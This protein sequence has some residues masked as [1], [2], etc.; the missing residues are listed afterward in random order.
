M[1]N[2]V[3]RSACLVAL[4]GFS[5]V[6][7]SEAHSHTMNAT[8]TKQ[9]EINAPILAAQKPKPT[10]D[11]VVTS[12]ETV[13]ADW[14]GA[15]APTKR[16]GLKPQMAS[17]QIMDDLHLTSSLR[18]KMRPEAL[19]VATNSV[20]LTPRALSADRST[21]SSVQV[22]PLTNQQYGTVSRNSNLSSSFAAPAEKPL[23][24]WLADRPLYELGTQVGV[25]R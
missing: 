1:K 17:A 15:E 22:A 16:L 8:W 18:P 21:W 13:S 7:L 3:F 10:P 25:F 12:V 4:T 19:V 9:T 20:Q 2:I 6:L 24:R 11:M 5:G 23:Q 14:P